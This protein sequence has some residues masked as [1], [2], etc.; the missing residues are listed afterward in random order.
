MHG[1][2]GLKSGWSQM[3]WSAVWVRSTAIRVCQSSGIINQRI[4]FTI[5]KEPQKDYVSFFDGSFLIAILV[6]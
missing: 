6:Y 4:L 2:Y 5:K 3:G 1:Q